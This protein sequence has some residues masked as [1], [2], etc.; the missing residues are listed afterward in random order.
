VVSDVK[1]EEQKWSKVKEDETQSFGR[2]VSQ[3]I[4]SA[5]GNQEM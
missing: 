3:R 5:S 4:S 2:R 1:E